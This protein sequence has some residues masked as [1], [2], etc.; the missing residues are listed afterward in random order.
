M[1]SS[2]LTRGGGLCGANH[3][4]IENCY[5]EGSVE[6]TSNTYGFTGGITSWCGGSILN[7]YTACV[8]TVPAGATSTSIGGLVGVAGMNQRNASLKYTIETSYWDTDLIDPD[9]VSFYIHSAANGGVASE[10]AAGLYGKTTVE[11][12]TEATFT[13][14][15]WDF[16][17][18][19]D[20]ETSEYPHLQF[21]DDSITEVTI[22]YE[23]NMI[24]MYRNNDTLSG[25]VVRQINELGDIGNYAVLDEDNDIGWFEDWDSFIQISTEED[26]RK[27]GSDEYISEYP[28]SGNYVLTND[29][30]VTDEFTPIG[31]ANTELEAFSGVFNGNGYCIK[32][33]F[34]IGNSNSR[35][36]GLFA[37]TYGAKIWNLG[38]DECTIEG[39]DIVGAISAWSKNTE[40]RNC[41]VGENVKLTGFRTSNA[42]YVGGIAGMCIRCTI[43]QCYSNCFI[44]IYASCAGGICGIS[45]E[46]KIIKIGRASCR[47]RV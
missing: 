30:I 36:Q 44:K 27:I 19:W 41:F 26:L 6:N 10:A 43:S 16:D 3:G 12:K 31:T 28:L 15:G 46:N 38:I 18:I 42:S 22:D 37:Y 21:E 40:F 29:I 11:L 4:S 45:W 24:E 1:C 23:R 32:G 9:P 39:Y 34:N 20:I 17:N 14:V 8:L 47:E 33:S 35:Y 2:D 5:F 25:G 7:C 13:G